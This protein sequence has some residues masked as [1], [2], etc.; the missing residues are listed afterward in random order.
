MECSKCGQ[1]NGQDAHFCANCGSSLIPGSGCINCSLEDVGDGH[2]CQHCNQFLPGP[3]GAKL[4][5]LE[6]RAG[7][8]ALD[9]PLLILTFVLGYILWWLFTLARG[10]TP[11]KRLLGIRAMRVDGRPS[12]WGWTFIREFL[13]ETVI[14][15]WLLGDLVIPWILD[16]LWAFRD[17]DRQTLHDK[18]VK[19]YVIDDRE[20]RN[21]IPKSPPVVA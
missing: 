14:F 17:K 7:A 2:F 13:V 10:Q 19:T 15:A 5:S 20:L 8:Y 4:A 21:T 9:V 11:G 16:L 18:I 6:R 12:D 3:K 1:T